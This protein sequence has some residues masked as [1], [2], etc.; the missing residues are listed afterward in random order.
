MADRDPQVEVT[1]STRMITNVTRPTLTVYRPAKDK[2]TGTALIICPGG[3]R[4]SA[5]GRS[6]M[7][8][9]HPSATAGDQPIHNRPGTSDSPSSYHLCPGGHCAATSP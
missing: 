4:A 8:R 7:G 6:L 9:Q 1:E 2:D 3:T 5:A